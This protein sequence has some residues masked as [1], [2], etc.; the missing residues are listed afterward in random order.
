M[1]ADAETERAAEPDPDPDPQPQPAAFT[2]EPPEDGVGWDD[3]A[4]V[5]IRGRAA[6]QPRTRP[7]MQ[8]QM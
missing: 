5:T 6:T 7:Q 3:P 2:R 8:P 1:S 4:E